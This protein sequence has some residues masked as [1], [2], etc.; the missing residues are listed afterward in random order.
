MPNGLS[1]KEKYMLA[2]LRTTEKKQLDWIKNEF[3]MQSKPL[4]QRYGSNNTK[5]NNGIKRAL[6]I[7]DDSGFCKLC[8]QVI[9]NK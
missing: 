2:N 1:E 5:L 9:K 7:I 8:G 4:L 3:Y 6:G